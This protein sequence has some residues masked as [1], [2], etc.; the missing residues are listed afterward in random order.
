MDGVDWMGNFSSIKEQL[1]AHAEEINSIAPVAT[2]RY[3][4]NG[5]ESIVDI[6]MDAVTRIGGG[7]MKNSGIGFDFDREGA[8]SI[9]THATGPELR[10]AAL[11]SPYVAK[12]GKLIA[13]QKNHENT[14]LTTLTFAAPVEI[15]G[16]KVNVGTVVQFTKNGRPRAVNVG[17]QDGAKFR[18]KT[19]EAFR[20]TSSRVDRYSQGTALDTRNASGTRVTEEEPEVNSE[21]KV[22][23]SRETDTS[24]NR[25]ALLT[26]DTVDRWLRDY[27]SK[28]NPKY[29]QAYITR[30]T[31][32]QFLDL[33]TSTMGRLAINRGTEDLDAD[34]LIKATQQNPLQIIIS[35][36][37]V[38]GHEGRHRM[39]ALQRAGV[40]SIPVLV[41]DSSNK[42][43]KQDV[44]D[45]ELRGQDFVH[46]RSYAIEALHDLIPLNYENRDRIVQEYGTQPGAERLNEKYG[47]ANTVKFSRETDAAYLAAVKA[48]DM[49]TA[50]RMV[51]EAAEKAGYT[52]KAY[53]GTGR[54]DRVGTGFRVQSLFYFSR[55]SASRVSTSKPS[56]LPLSLIAPP[57]E[58]DFARSPRASAT[59]REI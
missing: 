29:A 54:A 30:M 55:S 33:T 42:Y 49:D 39:N 15:N 18:I 47:V 11:A 16:D 9:N 4:H 32:K 44:A 19:N 12:Y 23:S 6:I 57:R 34:K 56:A 5:N 21:N 37:E 22:K 20:G 51:D 43:S 50:Q 13:G 59:T 48:G 27:A 45:M 46:S 7:R 2:V 14:G 41:F 10:A 52:I 35:D 26:E 1:S 36:G 3:V 31:P 58:V 17:T 24:Y 40:S 28:S 25:T 53:H 38:V 8:I